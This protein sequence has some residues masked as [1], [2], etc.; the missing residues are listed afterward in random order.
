VPE[1]KPRVFLDSNVIFSGLYSPKGAPGII[2]EH[3]IKGDISVVVSQQ[4]LEEIIRTVKEKLP[5]AD[6]V[7]YAGAQVEI[8]ERLDGNILAC[9][10]DKILT[11]QDAPPLATTLRA[12]AKDIPD[13]PALWKE[14]PPPKLPRVRI[15]GKR[16]RIWVG[17]MENDRFWWKDPV[18][19]ENTVN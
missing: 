11:P 14:P 10:K 18:K 8:Q 6:K 3:F 12:K 15:Y 13:Y 16:K 9:Y 1:P 19:R 4:V 17:P 2:P 5:D 7:S